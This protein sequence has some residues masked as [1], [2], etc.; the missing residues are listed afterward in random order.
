VDPGA[1]AV[2]SVD[3][4][5]DVGD[6]A[7]EGPAK[8]ATPIIAP[9]P[10]KNS[11]IGWGGVL[12]LGLIHRFEPD[13]TIKP[14]TGAVMGLASENGSWGVMGLEIARFK[15]DT[16][17]V[18]AV[19]GYMDLKYDFYGIGID[20]GEAGLS[21]PLN[22]TILMT[23]GM[24]M[25]RVVPNLYLGA[26]ITF[27]QT[28][29][30]LRDTAGL[31]FPPVVP[32]QSRAN[33]LA[34]GFI[35]EFDSRDDDYW[36]THGSLGQAK[37]SFFITNTGESGEFQ[38]YTASWSWYHALRGRTLVLAANINLC[39]AP[40]D[41]P[42][43][44]LCTLGTP[45]YSLRGYTQGRYRDGYAHVLQTEVR[46]HTAGRWGAVVFGGF[47]QVAD[48]LG[49]IGNAK[50]LPAGG[51]GLRF[52]LA[53][54]FPMHMRLDYAWGRDGGLLYFAVAEAM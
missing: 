31:P 8:G 22:Q 54:K 27:M 29:V 10:F 42:F 51:L 28:E 45:R 4:P 39:A 49:D 40:G 36:P 24:V 20:A 43:Y 15:R 21:V 33:L 25:R 32:D 38:R 2:P 18:R 50:V 9:I 1:G 11:Q 47:G 23:A 41:P 30:A 19:A 3:A 52:Q 17:R 35:A 44:G 34:P 46:G 5:D 14:S 6:G 7:Q 48:A 37:G 16:W 26:S 13:T 53:R 12:M